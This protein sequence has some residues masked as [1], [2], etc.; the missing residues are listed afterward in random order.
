MPVADAAGQASQKL[1]MWDAVEIPTQV[2]V[3][4]FGV[5]FLQQTLDR[6][7][8]VQGAASGA[9]RILFGLQVGLEDRF[10]D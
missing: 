8:G 6:L 1:R 3:D 2:R 10:E 5:A 7:H 4:H 9:V